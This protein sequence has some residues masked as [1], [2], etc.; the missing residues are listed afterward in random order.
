MLNV[1]KLNSNKKKF[2][3]KKNLPSGY[4][5][6]SQSQD[7]NLDLFDSYY[8]SFNKLENKKTNK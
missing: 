1:G 8:N 3:K 2:K 7:F 4:T 5:V 6:K